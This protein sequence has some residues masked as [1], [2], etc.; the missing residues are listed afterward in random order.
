ML[1]K[2]AA[3]VLCDQRF[4]AKIQLMGKKIFNKQWTARTKKL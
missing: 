3:S 1:P 2:R 4:E